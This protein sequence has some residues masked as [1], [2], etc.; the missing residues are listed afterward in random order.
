VLLV[1]PSRT[2]AVIVRK[3]LQEL[4]VA[5]VQ[6]GPAGAKALESIRAQRPDLV[7]S[8][9]HLADITGVELARRLRAD[10]ALATV[11]FVLISSETDVHEAS[12]L[13]AIADTVLLRKPFDQAQL[14]QALRQA[15][16]QLA[17]RSEKPS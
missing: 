10:P 5:E 9:M 7:L 4:G 8:A 2:Q 1:E 6:A 11:G 16:A 12:A 13:E 15:V 17:H 14:D 3:Y